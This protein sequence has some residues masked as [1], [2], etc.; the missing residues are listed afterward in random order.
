[1]LARP[2]L[3]ALLWAQT[4][5]RGQVPP[6][7]WGALCLQA[8]A[9]PQPA[10]GWAVCWLNDYRRLG[11]HWPS[12]LLLEPLPPSLPPLPGPPTPGPRPRPPSPQHRRLRRRH[13]S[14]GSLPK[15]SRLPSSTGKMVSAHPTRGIRGTA[16]HASL[17]RACRGARLQRHPPLHPCAPPSV[18]HACFPWRSLSMSCPCPSCSGHSSVATLPTRWLS[19]MQR[20][21]GQLRN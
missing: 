16:A 10:A 20:L 4:S 9:D 14:P 8:L 18:H 1:M 5:V 11:G 7:L 6:S 13:A 3:K 19:A 12:A 21:L 2:G 15:S 17:R